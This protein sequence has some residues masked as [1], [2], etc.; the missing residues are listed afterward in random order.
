MT[1]DVS[2]QTDRHHVT[3]EQVLAYKSRR[4]A[5]LAAVLDLTEELDAI[6]AQD[7]PDP[8]RLEH[9]FVAAQK[10][11]GQHVGESEA[12]DGLLEQIV[13]EEPNLFSRVELMRG[14]HGELTAELN[15]LI[16]ALEAKRN[17][18]ELLDPARELVKRLD[19]H[20]HRATGLLIDAYMLDLAA[21][22]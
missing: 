8:T 10:A 14:E 9:A 15:D 11:F 13:S 5:L 7:T 12:D 6:C 18:E 16:V 22:D 2:N 3:A 21:G 4:E 17:C 19:G 1:M 20:R